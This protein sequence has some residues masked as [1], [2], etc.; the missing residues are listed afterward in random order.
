ML[1]AWGEVDLEKIS[2]VS[3]CVSFPPHPTAMWSASGFNGDF[4]RRPV[5]SNRGASKKETRDELLR[6][7][8][9]ERENREVSGG[10]GQNHSPYTATGVGPMLLAMGEKGVYSTLLFS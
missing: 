4:R 10:N 6:R 3:S 1:C 9:K 8:Q 2:P 5:V 7:A